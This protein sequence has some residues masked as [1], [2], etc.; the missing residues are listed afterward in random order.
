[1]KCAVE[2]IAL[3]LLAV[4]L[5]CIGAVRVSNRRDSQMMLQTRSD[6][7]RL[8]RPFSFS[9]G[10]WESMGLSCS[11]RLF[12]PFDEGLSRGDRAPL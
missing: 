9:D 1:M 11:C 2:G 12:S 10:S 5:I 6:G 4:A 8:L 3:W 7:L